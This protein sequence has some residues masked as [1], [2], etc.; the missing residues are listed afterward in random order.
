MKSWKTLSKR[1]FTLFLCF[2]LF[3]SMGNLSVFASETDEENIAIDTVSI[4]VGESMQLN[5]TASA[6]EEN[7]WVSADPAIAAVSGDGTVTGEG[8]GTTTVEHTYYVVQEMPSEEGADTIY[9]EKTESWQ[10]EVVKSSEEPIPEPTP[11]PDPE[12]ESKMQAADFDELQAQIDAAGMVPTMIEVTA[13]I[14][15]TGDLTIGENQD[16]TL[17]G[18]SLVRAKNNR[19][20]LITVDGKLTLKEIVIDGGNFANTDNKLEKSIIL[21]NGKDASLQIEAGTVL[22]NNNMASE[23]RKS[24]SGGAVHVK[25]GTLSMYGGTITGNRA[26]TYGGGVYVENGIFDMYD[27]ADISGNTLSTYKVSSADGAGVY[28]RDGVF[29]MYGGE[30]SENE[31]GY[32]NQQSKGIAV[33]INGTSQFVMNGSA[34]IANNKIVNTF[35]NTIYIDSNSSMTMADQAA[36][37]KNDGHGIACAGTFTMENG[38]ISENGF[39]NRNPASQAASHGISLLE[40]GTAIIRDGTISKNT[41]YGVYLRKDSKLQMYGGLISANESQG[42]SS[43]PAKPVTFE[44]RG[45]EISNHVTSANGAGVYINFGDFSMWEGAVI[46]NNYSNSFHPNVTTWGGGVFILSGSMTMHGGE[47]SGNEAGSGGGG[48][49]IRSGQFNMYNGLITGNSTNTTS[50]GYHQGGGIHLGAPSQGSD[51]GNAK[52][53]MSGGTISNNSVQSNGGG[54][55]MS[56]QSSATIEKDAKII[57]NTAET[58]A[59]IAVYGYKGKLGKDGKSVLTT[60][61]GIIKGN[62]AEIYGGGIGAYG[63]FDVSV[64]GAK[65]TDNT[66]GRGGGIGTGY[67]NTICSLEVK[68]SEICRNEV[69]GNGGGILSGSERS[70]NEKLTAIIS[71]CQITDNHAGAEGGGIY[72]CADT[73][74]EGCTIS[75]NES[76]SSGGGI[77]SDGPV[78]ISKS[79]IE[80]NKVQGTA[81]DVSYRSGGGVYL[82]QSG[83]V[84]SECQINSNETKGNGGGIIVNGAV[85]E[86]CIVTENQASENGGGIFGEGNIADTKIDKNSAKNGGGI[87]YGK[88]QYGSVKDTSYKVTGGSI[89]ENQAAK[90]GGGIYLSGNL[91]VTVSGTQIIKNKA[92]MFGG[93]IHTVGNNHFKYEIGEGGMLCNNKAD[94]SGDDVSSVQ[95]SKNSVK[96]VIELP[97]V[98]KGE[99]AWILDDCNHTINGWYQ[100]GRISDI[101]TNGKEKR[102]HVHLSDAET[103]EA[104]HAQEF[105]GTDTPYQDEFLALKAAHN[106]MDISVIINR[107]YT[108][109]LDDANVPVEN[110]KALKKSIESSSAT[111]ETGAYTKYAVN[112]VTKEFSLNPEKIKVTNKAG[113]A[114][115][116]TVAGNDVLFSTEADEIYHVELVYELAE[117]NYTLQYEPNADG[118][119]V[120]ALPQTQVEGPTVDTAKVMKVSGNEP[121][122]EGFRF[123]G[124]NTK[125]DGSGTDYA[126]DGSLTLDKEHREEILYAQWE[127]A[128]A[129]KDPQVTID[130]DYSYNLNDEK[131]DLES[132]GSIVRDEIGE[133]AVISVNDYREYEVEGTEKIFV[134]DKENTVVVDENNNRVDF[135]VEDGVLSFAVAKNKTYHVELVYQLAEY[136]YEL[137]YDANAD[138]DTVTNLPQTQVEGPTADTAKDMTISK[139]IPVR[140]GYTFK[141]WATSADGEIVYPEGSEVS[142]IV[143]LTSAQRTATLYAVWEANPPTPPVVVIPSYTLTIH[144]VYENGTTAEPSYSSSMVGGTPYSVVSPIIENYT[145][146]IETVSGIMPYENVTV[147]VIYKEKTTDIDDEDPPLGNKPGNEPPTTDLPDE[148]PPLTDLPEQDPPLADLPDE[149]PPLSDLPDGNVPTSNSPK[150]GDTNSLCPWLLLLAI[151]GAGITGIS[152]RRKED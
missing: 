26:A 88:A 79:T 4:T 6:K 114:V 68:D 94:E 89:F 59:G 134:F 22:Q 126:K 78:R 50:N 42:V 100:D 3:L 28:V 63:Y 24:G 128:E 33:S 80:R 143:A 25:D 110:P 29:R 91:K 142:G 37:V 47:I 107:V 129:P 15:V 73:V 150:T 1:S 119:E 40:S 20:V 34:R 48:V 62:H 149:E 123:T 135:T 71:G 96:P 57:G 39:E 113:D 32:N 61:G 120:K 11:E 75:D 66:A 152:K 18:K 140:E 145:A 23:Q 14:L 127:R 67:S 146:S 83:A 104:L 60:N 90:N 31:L 92:K 30:V 8:L 77:Y 49:C 95:E 43:E 108:Y 54:I 84:V 82:K 38:V 136:T 53:Y 118:D 85:V 9:E 144:Y 86:K 122:R 137:H 35:T 13:D 138:G 130:R 109:S 98:P 65:I 139:E 17:T 101:S 97:T 87:Y 124:W 76:N 27:G 46:K 151:S 2:A 52:F 117:Y 116:F 70:Y 41:G 105:T 21:V 111:I 112:E 5:G 74:I 64:S 81:G 93:G 133:T 103:A 58:G 131:V 56:F 7:R 121:T 10:I 55:F 72:T 44:M 141:G 51:F 132:P 115:A 102:W 69:T 125:A 36:I 106:T 16:I 147:T 148:E 45:G 19:E 12:P 99:N